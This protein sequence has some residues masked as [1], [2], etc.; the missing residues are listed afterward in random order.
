MVELS[1]GAAGL[2]DRERE[3][4]DS[5]TVRTGIRI[6]IPDAMLVVATGVFLVALAYARSREDLG[7]AAPLFW[8][9]Q[10]IMFVFVFWRALNPSASSRERVV[11]VL[12]YAS[13][14]SFLR[15]AYSPEMFTFSDELQHWRALNTLLTAQHLYQTNYSL[16]VS[17]GYPGLE[18]VTAELIQTSSLGPFI[19]GILIS[20]VA[21][22]L[23]AGCILLL[24]RE[25]SQS[26]R[27]ACVGAVLYLA[28][29]HAAYFDTS[30][31][32]QTLA[33]PFLVLAIYF[34]IRFASNERGRYLNFGGCLA[35]FAILAITH[36]VTS[37]ATIGL[38]AILALA[39]AFFRASRHLALRL[40]LCATAGAG[41]YL[42]WAFSVAPYTFEYFSIHTGYILH[43][44]AHWRE[45]KLTIPKFPP[46]TPLFD[47]VLAPVSVLFTLILL[48]VSIGMRNRPPLERCF[49]WLALV[50]YLG[51]VATRFIIQ[52]GGELAG[53]AFTFTALFTGLAIAVV[54]TNPATFRP[55]IGNLSLDRPERRLIAAT[56]LAVVLFVGGI[57][58][59][60]PAW[61]QRLP[62]PFRIDGNP[63]GV[64]TVGTS[65]AEW[66]A[67]HLKPGSRVVG[68]LTSLTLLSTL[69]RVDPVF[70]TEELYYTEN[71]TPEDAEFIRNL[72]VMYVDVDMRM[73]QAAPMNSA[74]FWTD[75]HAFIGRPPL[76]VAG[77]VKFDDHP[78]IS[79]IYDSGYDHLFDMRGGRG[80]PYG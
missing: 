4:A 30:F 49:C 6:G 77:L 80:S 19:S 2:D 70:E 37:I 59:G 47:R 65:K 62:G 22:V 76:D 58:T 20:S 10:L 73:S 68:D 8:A 27:V 32:Y 13:T 39:T 17:R 74:Y 56:V 3:V 63:S 36:H 71:F 33:L 55:R 51:A 75:T 50:S 1:S 34:A 11:V 64:D 5:D 48:R 72:S 15:W 28:N 60:V 66:A 78:G 53:R 42:C 29:P 40:A 7:F 46:G 43:D 9:G 21:H 61:W 69:A 24:L 26:L 45:I 38:L 14:Q 57:A 12:L 54:L 31:I 44:L 25:V 35:C 67:T 18:N 16:P 41:V 52:N 23:L 79:R